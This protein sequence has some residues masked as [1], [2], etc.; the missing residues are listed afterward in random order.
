M[1]C[2]VP[3]TYLHV[4]SPFLQLQCFH[5]WHLQFNGTFSMKKQCH[6]SLKRQQ[7]RSNIG[8]NRLILRKKEHACSSETQQSFHWYRGEEVTQVLL[9]Q[10]HM[11]NWTAFPSISTEPVSLTKPWSNRFNSYI[12]CR[13]PSRHKPRWIKTD[14]MRAGGATG[15]Q[16]GPGSHT[17][18]PFTSRCLSYEE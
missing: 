3:L 1:F 7:Q 12:L 9:A 15:H 14:Q 16:H 13:Q 6:V 17:C 5:P 8:Q 2:D 4:K 18:N 11:W 10:I